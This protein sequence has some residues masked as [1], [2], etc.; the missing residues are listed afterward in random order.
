MCNNTLD[1]SLEDKK[2]YDTFN[3]TYTFF[4]REVCLISNF[5]KQVIRT[6]NNI[7]IIERNRKLS[8]D[9]LNKEAN[10]LARVLR[11]KGVESNKLVGIM[12]ERSVEMIIAVL[13]ILKAGGA[14][15][16]IDPFY[17][18]SRTNYILEDSQPIIV[19]T[20][21]AFVK[22]IKASA[23]I[24]DL[25]NEVFSSEENYN[26]EVI[27]T[28]N[29]LA[30]VIYTSGTTGKPKGVMIKQY[31]AVNY[32]EW[33][34]KVFPLNSSSTVLQKTSISFDPSVTEIFWCLFSGARLCMLE[35]NG[36]KDPNSIVQ[37][38]RNNNVTHVAFVASMLNLFTD[39]VLAK[40]AVEDISSLTNVFSQGEALQTHHVKK[41]YDMFKEH[42]KVVLTNLYGPT[43]ATIQTA[44]YMCPRGKEL[45]RIPIGKPI[46]N[47]RIYIVDGDLKVQPIDTIGE[48]CIAG[49]GLA[50]GYLNNKKITREKFIE[51]P[52]EEEE[53]VYRT[54]DLA[55]WLDDGNIEIYGRIDYQIKIKGF[56]IELG[57]I[58]ESLRSYEEIEDAVVVKKTIDSGQEYLCGY[59]ISSINISEQDLKKRL[60]DILPEY[61]I[62]SH[63]V[64]LK[65]FPLLSNG[66]LDRNRLPN[67]MEGK[68]NTK[69]VEPTSDI[70]RQLVE[71]WKQELGANSIGSECNFFESGGDSLKINCLR[72][73]IYKYL[74]IDIPFKVFFNAQTIKSLAKYI[75]NSRDKHTYLP[76]KK[77]EDKEY[78]PLSSA[79]KRIYILTQKRE[80]KVSYNIP[81]A[82]K[83]YGDID[84]NKLEESF[85]QLIKRHDSLRTSFEI[86]GYEPV[87]LV[88][89]FD[90]FDFNIEVLSIKPQQ[91]KK[92]LDDCLKPFELSKA[93]LFRVILLNLGQSEHILVLNMHHIVSDGISETILI[94]ELSQ[95]YS[96]LELEEASTQYKDFVMWNIDRLNKDYILPQ[97]KFWL[98]KFKNV[99]DTLDLPLDFSRPK[100]LNPKGIKS[101]F[102][103]TDSYYR[104]LNEIS[105][106]ENSTLFMIMLTT[107][108]ILMYKYTN[109]MDITIGSVLANRQHPQTEKVV[110]MF[111]NTVA[112]RSHID[113]NNSFINQL[114]IEKEELLQTIE[115]QDYPFEELVK[116]LDFDKDISHNPLFDVFFQ[117][118]SY[119]SYQLQLDEAV[120]TRHNHDFKLSFFDLTIIAT[121]MENK[122]IVDIL[123]NDS[124]F[125]EDTI[126]RFKKHFVNVVKQ[127]TSNA[128]RKI[129]N[130]NLLQD[131][132]KNKLLNIFN[133]TYNE[134]SKSKTIY[135]LF[136]EQVQAKPNNT[137]VVFGE[138]KLSYKELNNKS[139]RLARVLIDKGV[140]KEVIVGILAQRSIGTVVAILAIMKA[141]GTYLPIDPQYPQNRIKFLIED[142][143]TEILFVD[144]ELK[145][146]IPFSGLK[147]DMESISNLD[148][149]NDE[150]NLYNRSC[151][152]NLAY[153][154]YT[155]G[156]TGKPKGCMIEHRNVVNYL[157]WAEKTYLKG[158]LLTFPLFS[159][160]SFDLTV[161]SLLLPLTTGNKV[162]IYKDSNIEN[163]FEDNKCEIIKLTPSH[164]KLIRNKEYPNSIVK[165]MILG[166]EALETELVSDVLKN[167]KNDIKVFNEYGPTEATV[168]CMTYLYDS[169]ADK[170]PTIPIGKPA[171]NVQIHIMDKNCS[172]VPIGIKGEIYIAGDGIGRGYLNR[173][174]LSSERFVP[175]PFKN[176]GKMYKTGDYGRWLPN[177]NIEY[178]GRMDNQVKIRGYR[179]ELCEIEFQLLKNDNIENAVVISKNDKFGNQYLC[180]YY[181]LKVENS[182]NIEKTLK[183][184]LFN[185]LPEYM[186]PSYFVYV[187]TIPLTANGKIDYLA[188]PTPHVRLNEEVEKHEPT[189]VTE[190]K[191]IKIWE[192]VLPVKG[193]GTDK[194]FFDLGGFSLNA[195]TAIAKI[196]REFKV[197]LSLADFFNTPVIKLLAQRI[198]SLNESKV[199]QI[200]TCKS[201]EYYPVSKIQKEL[202]VLNE[203]SK[204]G[205]GLNST[206]VFMVHGDIDINRLQKVM[207]EIILRHEMLRTSFHIINKELVQKVHST[208]NIEIKKVELESN[209]N[210]QENIEK[211]IIPF[212]L[213]QL[214]LIRVTLINLNCTIDKYE[215]SPHPIN[216]IL[217]IDMNHMI[218]DGVSLDILTNDFC[219][220]YEGK[221][222]QPLK[223]HYKDYSVWQKNFLQTS[224]CK[225]QKSFWQKTLSGEIPVLNMPLDYS[226]PI[227]LNFS[228]YTVTRKINKEIVNSLHCIAKNNN[229]TF[230]IVLLTAYNVLLNK[231]TGQE[232]IIVGTMVAGRTNSDVQN[233]I[234]TFIN[235]LPLRNSFKS[236][237]S[238]KELL[239]KIK[240]NTLN[241]F[242]NQEYPYNCML[243]DCSINRV[244]NRNPLVDTIFALQNSSKADEIIINNEINLYPYHIQDY[245]LLVD[246]YLEAYEKDENLILQFQYLTDLFSKNTA[247]MILVNY[248]KILLKIVIDENIKLDDINILI[249]E[250]CSSKNIFSQQ[251]E[252]EFDW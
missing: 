178:Y 57:E 203:F 28:S 45:E 220:L 120:I 39:Y 112:L 237:M 236:S 56:R 18:E 205:G 37:A 173:R 73:K 115:N 168:G 72:L 148:G 227:K 170:N 49:V 144:N 206:K 107:L 125:A 122:I 230:F 101:S 247:E 83:I 188:L 187:K 11:R 9:Q 234:G 42:K 189:N 60:S 22:K 133:N 127:I 210:L 27:G 241:A 132:E 84:I 48:L 171:D 96:G 235:T 90:S 163:V 219:K 176:S 93:P 86:R 139:N 246:F 221:K 51:N 215:Y 252:E 75:E 239:V 204:T 24:I 200:S 175:N 74:K 99:P 7:A 184:N 2:L 32:L 92:Y 213:T 183:E 167:Y 103:I 180:A 152:E 134:Y 181:T 33:M 229:S 121:D 240:D 192:S 14:Y 65:K 20:K 87:Q 8:Y 61:M 142:S 62:P 195:M 81:L 91:C 46:F 114:R 207:N 118:D 40:E 78:Y 232:D 98:D 145:K 153:I 251:E 218:T 111:A 197:R 172:L 12:I 201:A 225:N 76:I 250:L 216:Q 44:Y 5:E 123:Y 31:S 52:F 214:P 135:Q 226:R 6:P 19:I 89:D 137:A 161:T 140:C 222:L 104:L 138:E 58:E 199:Q 63:M 106:I 1:L 30:Y 34:I 71:F 54:G 186:I 15:L 243:E 67:P 224:Q 4:D 196:N 131:D 165:K 147:I 146:D 130:I 82:Y 29:D 238:F 166:G 38:I 55:R 136:E 155:S 36:E 97:K 162:I 59:L 194:S 193:F 182:N 211:F 85:R 208:Y 102:E 68:V 100:M 128:T 143:S 228:A 242:D 66:K 185:V 217:I 190:E 245:S 43:E 244:G 77:V 110:G 191:L 25:D 164:L 124:I 129:K 116:E 69:L 109:Q 154:I 3:N 105:N 16:P 108:K 79:Q 10:K 35:V 149:S 150:D 158:E 126:Q 169:E 117:L 70:E 156:S 209:E 179:I 174:E 88:N 177:G 198:L 41:F 231:Y 17:P 53:R 23:V 233:V 212:E 94:N 64:F 80:D 13:A 26:L 119:N 113:E 21:K 249:H 141:G 50:E 47:N 223:I 151:P 159:S 95:L 248:E 160:L 157:L 202:F